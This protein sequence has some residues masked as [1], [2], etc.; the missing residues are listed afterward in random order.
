M[1]SRSRSRSPGDR[2]RSRTRSPTPRSDRG[3]SAS[4]SPVRRRDYDS[5]SPSRSQTPAPRR[6]GRYRSES[7]SRSRGRSQSPVVRS[8]KIVVE[9]L[10]K[11]INEGHLEEIFSQFGP[12]KDLDLPINRTYG[13]NRGTAYIL[14]DH[15]ADAEEAIAHMHEAQIDGAVINATTPGFQLPLVEAA[16]GSRAHL[17]PGPRVPDPLARTDPVAVLRLHRIVGGLDPIPTARDPSLAPPR[18][19][20]RVHLHLVVEAA[21][22]EAVRD[23][24][25]DLARQPRDAAQVRAEMSTAEGAR[26][27]TATTV[28]KAV[29]LA[30]PAVAVTV[31]LE[32][33]L[34]EVVA[35]AASGAI[36]EFTRDDEMEILSMLWAADYL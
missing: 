26:V 19:L 7:R 8:T 27:E 13:T 36:D 5:R 29:E 24:T 1:A 17:M 15:E 16:A 3:R 14:Y 6:N 22:T 30:P 35:V 34:V 25:H 18:D 12:I 21:G 23:L 4:R 28:T 33:A 32:P 2:Y 20:L 10:T 31:A 9:R 11:N